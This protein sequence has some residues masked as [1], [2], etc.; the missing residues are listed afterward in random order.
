MAWSVGCTWLPHRVVGGALVAQVDGGLDGQAAAEEQPAPV[1]DGL[2]EARVGQE[3]LDGVVAEEGRRG[4]H[5]AVVGGGHLEAE[6]L[7]LRGA[8]LRLG[9]DVELGH[10]R[11]HRVA[12]LLGAVRVVGRVVAGRVLHHAG[13]Q[14]CLTQGQVGRRLGEV[15]PGGGLDAVGA[16]TEVGDVEVAL[17]D[18]VLGVLLLE[19]DGVAQLVDLALVGVGGGGLLLGLGLRLVDQGHLHHLLGDRRAAL[20]RT[21]VGLVGDEGAQRAAEVEGA[22]L[23]EA[24][25]LDGDDRL[26]HDRRDLG[27]RDVHAVLVVEGGQHRAVAAQQ[28]GALGQRLGGEVRGD[29][30][31]AVRD[32]A[33]RQPGDGRERDGQ[34][35]HQHAHDGGHG[36]HD[37]EVGH[38]AGRPKAIGTA[39]GHGPQGT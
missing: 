2:A 39:R 11:E 32:R 13:Q 34:A 38:D 17:E 24:V 14:R 35:G 4:G 28:A 5:A 23:V 21:G 18:P 7:R 31:H 20:R 29:L 8:G 33:R 16:V 10:P 36:D 25:V 12:A 6:A 22:V 15:V 1:V 30:V 9:D 37:A 27:Q 26:A 3:V 19:R